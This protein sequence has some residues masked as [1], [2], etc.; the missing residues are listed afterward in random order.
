[1]R[2]GE[3]AGTGIE[4]TVRACWCARRDYPA[5]GED[6][7]SQL[8]AARGTVWSS[9]LHTQADCYGHKQQR[10]RQRIQSNATGKHHRA[11]RTGKRH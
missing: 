7:L 2:R 10:D 1:M 3:R 6:A 9:S 8:E 5:A 4:L 11:S